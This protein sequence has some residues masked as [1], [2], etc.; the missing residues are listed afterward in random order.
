MSIGVQAVRGVAAAAALGLV[1]ACATSDGDGASESPAQP[2]DYRASVAGPA[3]ACE[4]MA[5]FA[6]EDVTILWAVRRPDDGTRPDHCE[7]RAV[8][9]PA[10]NVRVQLPDAWNGRFFMAGNGGLAGEAVDNRSGPDGDPTAEALRRGF[11]AAITD[12]GHA[13]VAL[14]PRTLAPDA[15]PI[16]SYAVDASFAA[17][18]QLLE[19]YAYRA[20]HET[21]VAGKAITRAYY[22][23]DGLV[24]S[25]WVGCSTGGRQGLMSAQRFPEDFDGV[26]AGAP[27]SDY[28][29]TLVAVL[30]TTDRIERASLTPAQLDLVADAFD[31]KCDALDGL[32]DGLVANVAACAFTPSEELPICTGS[33]T[34]DECLTRAQ[35]A[36]LDEIVAGPSANGARLHAGLPPETTRALDPATNPWS[37]TWISDTDVAPTNVAIHGSSWA[38]MVRDPPDPDW[39][40][41]GFDFARDP[42]RLAELSTLLDATD[43]NLDAFR[44][45]GGKLLMYHGTADPGLV[46]GMSVDYR[47]AV[48]ARYGDAAAEFFRMFSMPGMYHCR[49]GYGP[50]RFDRLDAIV[51]WVEGGPAPDGLVATEVRDGVVL[52][53][54]PLCDHPSYARYD[55]GD[56]GDAASFRCATP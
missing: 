34:G 46:F 28:T 14:P 11:A 21:V 37:R 39:D 30:W 41:R 10:I 3:Q 19:D 53:A 16:I 49:G 50:D 15:S 32:V 42:A 31:A 8:I 6:R 25:Y 35:A 56:P 13:R 51:Q 2:V 52:R 9:A 1:A 26:V 4:A 17:D 20:V 5:A 54:R 47:D 12:T 29:G 44:D 24:A 23:A 33:M 36:L 43:P 7:V 55:G 27:I 18:P 48:A 38:Y 22:D 45:R 40:W